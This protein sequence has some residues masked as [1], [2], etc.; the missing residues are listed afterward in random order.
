MRARLGFSISMAVEF[1][2]YLVD[3]VTAVGDQRFKDKYYQEFLNRR[4]RSTVIMASHQAATIKEFC[5]MAAVLFDGHITLYDTVDEGMT[6][7]Q[8]KINSVKR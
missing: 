8:E 6:A 5:D 3:E 2:C 4:N 1:D 7:Y